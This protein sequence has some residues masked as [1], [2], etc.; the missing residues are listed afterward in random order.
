MCSPTTFCAG[1]TNAWR[2]TAT[3]ATGKRASLLGPN[4]LNSTR[5]LLT[6][7]H[8][9][10]IRQPSQPNDEAKRVYQILGIQCKGACP[11]KKT[12][13]SA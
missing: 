13:I 11:T 6:D 8:I 4:D 3:R 1:S 9:I 2:P 10:H 12:E 5:L 7:G